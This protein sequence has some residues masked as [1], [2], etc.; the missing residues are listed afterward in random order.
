MIRVLSARRK[1]G[2]EKERDALSE[3]EGRKEELEE[4]S[5]SV[6]LRLMH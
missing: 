6:P 4:G 3:V 5:C 2:A 1:E